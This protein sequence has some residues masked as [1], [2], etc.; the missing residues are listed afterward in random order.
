[1]VNK[2]EFLKLL[3]KYL[4][5]NASAEEEIFLSG[6]YQR[7]EDK[8]EWTAAE[9]DALDHMESKLI[10]RFKKSIAQAE[11]PE[12]GGSSYTTKSYY[13]YSKY[14]AAAILL[15]V[16]S[17]GIGLWLHE[18]PVS[19]VSRIFVDNHLEN[20]ITHRNNSGSTERLVFADQSYVDLTAGSKVTYDRDFAGAHRQVY[21]VGEGFFQ[22]TKDHTKP[23]IVY[24][25]HVVAKVLGTS[26]VVKSGSSGSAAA[27]LVK[28]GKVSVF[29]AKEFT[30]EN[31]EPNLLDGVIVIPNHA[32]SLGLTQ[33]LELKLAVSP[34]VLKP[35]A[36]EKFDF[37]HTPVDTV[38]SRLQDTYGIAI[39][40]DKV[41]MGSCSLSVNM[42]KED[43]YQKLE[44]VCRTIG[45]SYRVRNGNVYVSGAGCAR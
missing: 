44:L 33:E 41:K 39:V 19:K 4:A 30:K 9:M 38:F 27:V 6:I 16:F 20:V 17:A 15:I 22:I 12:S 45:A 43:F 11:L 28:T 7:M 35:V 23:F 13:R 21:L 2:E 3:D 37:D 1:M 40:Y 42:G 29:K 18:S 25:D 36:V 14:M 26:F 5:G 32:V 34:A 10:L 8:Y 31:A 24:T